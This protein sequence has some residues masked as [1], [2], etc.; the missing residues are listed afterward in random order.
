MV[1]F[2]DLSRQ[3]K[4]VDISKAK[5]SIIKDENHLQ[6]TLNETVKIELSKKPESILI[7]ENDTTK[8]ILAKEKD[9]T[10]K[11]TKLLPLIFTVTGLIVGFLMN[12]FYEWYMNRKKI[13]KSGKRWNIELKT[14]E[15]PLKDQIKYIEEFEISVA[16]REWKYNSLELM[17]TINSQRF[18][19]LDKNDLMDYIDNLY[20][21]PWYRRLF[22]SEAKNQEQ[23][24]KAVKLSNH[25]HGFID[26]LSHNFEMLN[27]KWNEFQDGISTTTKKLNQDMES[28]NIQFNTLN[29]EIR[30]DTLKIYN[31]SDYSSFFNL[32]FQFISMLQ[33]N[34][35]Y[36]MH[37]FQ[38]DFLDPAI[39]ELAK[40]AKDQRILPI[41]AS[42]SVLSNDLR[43]IN[44]EKDYVLDNMK[45]LIIR[46]NKSLESLSTIIEKTRKNSAR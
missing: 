12:R 21:F 15:E 26:V 34:P 1:V 38:K 25:I 20:K 31:K 33:Q 5:I 37:N 35:N 3:I 19:S 28:F 17:T 45:E 39:K 13:M 36:N 9:S 10:T 41:A 16:K 8:A 22:I 24:N 29:F 27:N 11:F 42:I 18:S 40:F 44:G 30:N 7:K 23:Y 2:T 43:A 14:L 6:P 4:P 32:Y 46:Y